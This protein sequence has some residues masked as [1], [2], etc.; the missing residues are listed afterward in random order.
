MRPDIVP[1][2]RFL[3]YELTDHTRMRRKLS[4]LQR[5]DPLILVLSRGRFC[6]KIAVAYTPNV[7]ITTDT[8]LE[9]SE[10]RASVGATWIFLSDPRRLVQQDLDIQEYTDPHHDPMI[11]QTFVLAPGL[12]IQSTT[13][14]GSGAGPRLRTC[15]ATCA[16]SRARFGR[17]VVMLISTR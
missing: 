1:G 7:T 5:N 13:A 6:P 2:A 15:G 3:D 17:I 14:T 10:F 16:K 8:I 4:E 9:L 12:I 11:P